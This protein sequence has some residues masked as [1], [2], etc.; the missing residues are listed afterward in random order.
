MGSLISKMACLHGR[1]RSLSETELI[2]QARHRLRRTVVGGTC[3]PL[4]S[5]PCSD[6][7]SPLAA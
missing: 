2:V 3:E 7:F 5:F 4:R 6:T 1:G